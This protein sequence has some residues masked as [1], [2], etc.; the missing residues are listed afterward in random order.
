MK[1][2]FI[3]AVISIVIFFGAIEIILR[4][5]DVGEDY[6]RSPHMQTRTIR[7]QMRSGI[8]L[9][10]KDLLWR[11]KPEAPGINSQGFRSDGDF[12]PDKKAGA[13]RIAVLGD[14]CSFGWGIKRYNNT[15]SSL[16]E[17]RLNELFDSPFQVYNFSVPGYS[18]YQI[19]KLLEK[20][21]LPYRPDIVII[22]TAW[23]DHWPATYFTDSQQRVE[24]PLEEWLKSQLRRSKFYRVHEGMIRGLME[25]RME[26]KV[27]KRGAAPLLR[28]PEEEFVSNISEICRVCRENGIRPLFLSAPF[29]E[30]S[31][32]Y[33]FGD[34]ETHIRYRRLLRERVAGE[35]G[36]AFV[37]LLG[38]INSDLRYF[39]P[40]GI[41]PNEAG[42]ER[43]A[44][45][46]TAALKDKLPSLFGKSD[47]MH[48]GVHGEDI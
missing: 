26:Q 19:L 25:R 33:G 31:T 44:A 29:Y 11:L 35:D 18:S 47:R 30:A 32:F 7:F 45:E 16:L 36:A 40:D 6:V 3:F 12:T 9:P 27:E 34:A 48:H 38:G 14:S 2:R 17:R 5:L 23:N 42:H 20:N 10:D 39:Q 24:G 28:V 21:V 8:C 37:E 46:I 1:K 4:A 41:H 22:S 15:Y 43:I 13:V